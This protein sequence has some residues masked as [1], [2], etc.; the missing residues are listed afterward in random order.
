MDIR[1]TWQYTD[2]GILLRNIGE[3]T[4]R[5]RPDLQPNDR[6]VYRRRIFEQT[7]PPV[8]VGERKT[9]LELKCREVVTDE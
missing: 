3:M 5:Y 2:D 9:Y 6:L 4:L 7:A 8:N 1:M